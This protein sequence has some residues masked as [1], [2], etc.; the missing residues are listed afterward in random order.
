[1]T[2]TTLANFQGA[3]S[4]D[5][6]MQTYAL[7]NHAKA[8]EAFHPV[9]MDRTNVVNV[10]SD[11]MTYFVGPDPA[12]R[13]EADCDTINWS[14]AKRSIIDNDSV[15]SLIDSDPIA[16]ELNCAGPLHVNFRDVDG[17]LTGKASTLL[18][19]NAASRSIPFE[20]GIALSPGPCQFSPVMKGY[21][22]LPNST[23]WE[24]DAA[25]KPDPVPFGGVF[26]DPQHFVLESRD[27][28]SE[29]RNF[30][31]VFFNVSGVVEVA[32]P[33]MDHGWCFAYTCQKRLS[34]FWTY[35]PG[36]LQGWEC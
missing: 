14:R 16:M 9:F 20:Q 23:N 34:T 22:C 19:Y 3:S 17:S 26:G 28:D 10:A 13:N 6:R 1:M 29:D 32:V 4:C 21:Q 15:G 24:L 2:G 11:G 18:G 31:P 27:P 35:L 12:W 36:E 7:G 33:A 8:P 30:S 25:L 5:G